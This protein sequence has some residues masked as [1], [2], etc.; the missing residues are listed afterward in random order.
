ML[1]PTGT[2]WDPCAT[3]PIK[4]VV[5]FQE[6]AED[7]V[8]PGHL[9]SLGE[10]LRPVALKLGADMARQ[11]D[12][13]D[14]EDD[15]LEFVT[16]HME[17]IGEDVKQIESEVNGALAVVASPADANRAVGRLEVQLER[18]VAHYDDVRRVNP[19]F[20]VADGW[21]LLR[22]VYRRVLTEIRVWLDE[23]VEVLTEPTAALK[24]RGISTE[25]RVVLSLPLTITAPPELEQLTNW[26]EEMAA[27]YKDA[28]D[29]EDAYQAKRRS[30]LGF[31]ALVLG[32]IGLGWMIGGDDDE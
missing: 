3:I 24:E 9:T 7:S 14:Q 22:D 12:R 25:G 17:M 32:A 16:A 31:W 15:M 18:L 20:E 29:Y 6:M 28:M 8:L 21:S 5:G 19:N 11:P 4:R 1:R 13:H 10:A 27:A 26:A 2:V 30:S 23:L